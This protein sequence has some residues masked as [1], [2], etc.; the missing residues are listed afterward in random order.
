M[1][2]RS[3]LLCCWGV[4]TFWNIS[5]GYLTQTVN[6]WTLRGRWLETFWVIFNNFWVI[7]TSPKRYSQKFSK[8]NLEKIFQR[9]LL[10]SQN[11]WNCKVFLCLKLTTITQLNSV[12]VL[13]CCSSYCRCLIKVLMKWAQFINNYQKST[14]GGPIKKQFALQ[15]RFFF[16]YVLPRHTN[17]M[18]VKVFNHFDECA[19]RLHLFLLRGQ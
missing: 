8:L 17:I 5:C 15:S 4:L 6:S 16:F 18:T 11:Y 1:K 3:G 13:Y 14:L 12:L 2:L 10:K 9:H 7:A 19:S